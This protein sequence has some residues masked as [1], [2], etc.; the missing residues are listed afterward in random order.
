MTHNVVT[1][2][3]GKDNSPLDE[4]IVNKA[5]IRLEKKKA[6][7]VDMKWLAPG[8]ACDIIFDGLE[9][10]QVAGAFEEKIFCD[11]IVQKN[12]NRKKKLLIS[13]MDSTIINQECIDEIAD[14]LGLK[15]KVAAITER[16]MNGELDFSESLI[17]RVALLKGLNESELEDV[18]ENNISVMSGAAE[19]VQTMKKNGAY[20]LLVSGGFTFFADKIADRLG[21]DD[22]KANILEITEGLLTGKVTPPILDKDSKL[23]SLNKVANQLELTSSDI[24]A[25]GDGANDLPM[26]M[27][28]GLGV[29]Y[30]AKPNVKSQTNAKIDHADLRALLYAQGYTK[31]EI[32]G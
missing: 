30:H 4:A 23:A 21:F 29:A 9:I 17:E 14:R 10:D 15:E 5:F 1:L 22:N 8:E 18:Y 2:I 19:L 3:A 13:D 32:S 6:A 12:E 7:I 11:F 16:A 31:E 28:A 20:C 25:V 24:L 27:A 26:L